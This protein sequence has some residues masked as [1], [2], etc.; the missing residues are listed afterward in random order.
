MVAVAVVVAVV[1]V[2][3]AVVVVVVVAV[4]VVVGIVVV[5]VVVVVVVAVVVVGI[6]VVVVVDSAAV[7]VLVTAAAFSMVV[8]SYTAV[9]AADSQ[10]SFSPSQ[11]SQDIDSDQDGY[12]DYEDNC[13][14]TPNPGQQDA[15]YDDI[16][17]VC[18]EDTI[19]GYIAGELVAGIE[20]TISTMSCS[21]RT[22]IATLITDA[23][24]YYAVGNLDDQWYEVTPEDYDCSF[25]P[26]S[27]SVQ[28]STGL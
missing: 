4:V 6:V 19:Y 26:K 21:S 11:I 23:D 14:G 8:F 9:F 1:V 22:I 28:I 2:V 5:V 15:D 18:D 27:A 25:S 7:D 12:Y 16:G 3:T 20:V 10:Y 17:D 24:G 13:P